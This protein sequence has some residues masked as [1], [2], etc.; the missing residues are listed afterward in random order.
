MDEASAT[1]VLLCE[2]S[3]SDAMPADQLAAV[4]AVLE[5]TKAA[6]LHVDDLCGAVE[7][8]LSCNESEPIQAVLNKNVAGM[9]DIVIIA[10]AERAVKSLLKWGEWET[11]SSKIH[12]LSLRD[13]RCADKL[14]GLL[15]SSPSENVSPQWVRAT[16]EW[17]PWFPVID[18]DKCVDCGKCFEFCLFGVYSREAS[19]VIVEHPRNCKNNCPAC[20]R[21]CPVNAIIFPKFPNA[22]I[23][24]ESFR[25]TDSEKPETSILNARKAERKKL[26]SARF[27]N[28][29]GKVDK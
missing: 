13:E 14:R 7:N 1:C 28:K 25:T 24:G 15:A 16:G 5:E 11:G 27:E 20:A 10:C 23:N 17:I 2:C 21:V 3:I 18:R 6:V 19:K 12:F 4:K 22:P 29:I 9:N 26:F 8:G